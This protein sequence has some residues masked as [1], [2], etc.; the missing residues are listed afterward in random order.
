MLII[1][2][3][4]RINRRNYTSNIGKESKRR[5]E[6][7]VLIDFLY[8]KIHVVSTI[9][10]SFSHP[11]LYSHVN[12]PYFQV[13]FFNIERQKNWLYTIKDKISSSI[14]NIPYHSVISVYLISNNSPY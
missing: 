7:V 9:I 14:D 13:N 12:S 1:S 6:N 10:G 4:V 2:L 3:K 8:L 11:M 5:I